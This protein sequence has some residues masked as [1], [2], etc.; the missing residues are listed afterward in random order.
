[1]RAQ[2]IRGQDP[3]EALKIGIQGE[4]LKVAYY[5]LEDGKWIPVMEPNYRV[6]DL[7]ADWLNLVDTNYLFKYRDKKSGEIYDINALGLS[8][9]TII[10]DDTVY[11]IP[12]GPIPEA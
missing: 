12:E 2:F 5:E 1:M 10:Y 11:T 8:G 9:R 3:K 6:H 4:V 7:F